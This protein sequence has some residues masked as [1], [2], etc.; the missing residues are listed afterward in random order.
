M[1]E[2]SSWEMPART[3]IRHVSGYDASKNNRSRRPAFR[4]SQTYRAGESAYRPASKTTPGLAAAAV[5][6]EWVTPRQRSSVRRERA[7]EEV[8]DLAEDR[9]LLH[10]EGLPRRGAHHVGR[11]DV[12]LD[13]VDAL[14]AVADR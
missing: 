13:R 14:V 4:H 9:L 11:V 8:V 12:E 10:A 1:I 5:S 3:V 7:D 2:V 6:L